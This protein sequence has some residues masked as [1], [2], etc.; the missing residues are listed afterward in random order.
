M[1]IIRN[2]FIKGT[3]GTDIRIGIDGNPLKGE[4]GLTAQSFSYIK[5]ISVL[6]KINYDLERCV[7]K[8]I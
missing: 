8:S 7:F 5:S 2:I 4:R 1:T 6:R 3:D